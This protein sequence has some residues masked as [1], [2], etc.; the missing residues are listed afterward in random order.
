MGGSRQLLACES[1]AELQV[2]LCHRIFG[3]RAVAPGKPQCQRSEETAQR[4]HEP[5]AECA[6]VRILQTEFCQKRSLM[7][8][9]ELD[10]LIVPECI[11]SVPC[12]SHLREQIHAIEHAAGHGFILT[13]RAFDATLNT[14]GRHRRGWIHA[15]PAFAV[16]PDFRPCV[17]VRLPHDQVAAQSVVFATLITKYYVGRD[18]GGTCHEGEGGCE[19]FAESASSI[20]EEIID[21]I[22]FEARRLERVIKL[23]LAKFLQYRSRE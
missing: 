13:Q 12:E 23:L 21:R 11:E 10:H 9:S 8:L 7:L 18:S 3:A 22:C 5:Q 20:E 16:D 14:L 4:E 2:G 1:Q 6:P 19:V 17:C 15:N